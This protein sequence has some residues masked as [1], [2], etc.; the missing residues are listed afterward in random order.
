MTK[1]KEAVMPQSESDHV[2]LDLLRKWE[3]GN[4]EVRAMF[5]GLNSAAL[6]RME[7]ARIIAKEYEGTKV[8]L[9]DKYQVLVK[10]ISGNW[11]RLSIK[12]LDREPIHDW[13]DLQKIKSELVGPE[14]EGVE[15]YPAE[16]RLVD[17][18]NQ[19]WLHC[20]TDPTWRFPFGFNDGRLV[21]ATS[22]GKSKQRPFEKEKK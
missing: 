7:A 10:E 20:C 2:I 12:R 15:L 21:S 1:F 4:P 18:A 17:Q 5:P 13:R 3:A 19:Y 16:S 8:Y 9:N 22:I 6:V 11:V 14:C